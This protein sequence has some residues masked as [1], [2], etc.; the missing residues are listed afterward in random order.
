[1][2]TL[3]PSLQLDPNLVWTLAQNTLK[4]ALSVWRQQL[5]TCAEGSV[6]RKGNCYICGSAATLGELQE[7]L[8]VMHLRCGQCGA[9]WQFP[10]LQC[11]YC[12]NQDHRTLGYLYA[13]TQS[14]KT[15]VQVCDRCHRYLKVITTFAP[16]PPELLA[17]EDLATLHLDYIAQA[18]GYER[19]AI[20]QQ[21]G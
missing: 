17:V 21:L 3:A 7:N 8:Q 9:D 11:T 18:R 13:E 16:T 14:E 6:W 1:M 15:R 2:I 10:R 19:V 12:G 20:R 4:P 5:A